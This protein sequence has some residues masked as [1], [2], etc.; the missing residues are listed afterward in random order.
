M[1]VNEYWAFQVVT[2]NCIHSF[3]VC[4][5]GGF[6]SA[7]R[8]SRLTRGVRCSRWANTLSCNKV[9]CPEEDTLDCTPQI[10]LL[11]SN[12]FPFSSHETS[13]HTVTGCRRRFILLVAVPLLQSFH[14]S[15]AWAESCSCSSDRF[16]PVVY[17]YFIEKNFTEFPFPLSQ[18]PEDSPDLLWRGQWHG[19]TWE[20]ILC[21]FSAGI[22]WFQSALNSYR[23]LPIKL[24]V[25]LAPSLKNHFKWFLPWQSRFSLRR[26]VQKIG[27]Q[28][29]IKMIMIF[30]HISH[31]EVHIGTTLVSQALSV[32]RAPPT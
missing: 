10:F 9:T 23:P 18:K 24:I 12:K 4:C 7:K 28:R 5:A 21:I 17:V 22:H 27:P 31:D 14:I 29:K 26:P 32:G 6:L 30:Q 1:V 16:S 2:R 25:H 13:S 11:M 8:G 15:H 20:W 3:C 19:S